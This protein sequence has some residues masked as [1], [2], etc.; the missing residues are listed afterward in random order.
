MANNVSRY[1]PELLE[2]AVTGEVYAGM[3]PSIDGEWVD[4]AGYEQL[5]ARVEELEARNAELERRLQAWNLGFNSLTVRQVEEKLRC[6]EQEITELKAHVERLH[7]RLRRLLTYA[8]TLGGA[9]PSSVL[10]S[11][12]AAL[13]ET[14]SQSLAAHDREVAEK[15]REACLKII[16]QHSSP[17]HSYEEIRNLDLDEVLK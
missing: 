17:G 5:R 3:K 8:E 9:E 15:V 13:N 7:G 4:I 16:H 6:S 11:C 10:A 14:K 12:E 2:N 1:T